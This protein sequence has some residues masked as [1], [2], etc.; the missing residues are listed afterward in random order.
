MR[1]LVNSEFKKFLRHFTAK[2]EN[3][4]ADSK[5]PKKSKAK[6]RFLQVL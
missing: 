1:A 2:T 4:S 5:N 6:K 3:F